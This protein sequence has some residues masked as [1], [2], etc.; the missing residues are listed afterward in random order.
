MFMSLAPGVEH[1]QSVEPPPWNVQRCYVHFEDNHDSGAQAGT[2]KSPV[3]TDQSKKRVGSSQANESIEGSTRKH[4]Q[5]IIDW[6]EEETAKEDASTYML[7][8]RQKRTKQTMQGDQPHQQRGRKKARRLQWGQHQ[9]RGH[10]KRKPGGHHKMEARAPPPNAQA[11]GNQGITPSPL[12]IRA[13]IYK[14][15]K[16]H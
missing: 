2:G 16:T 7:N 15:L 8:P 6:S 13:Q 12:Y 3:T 14:F 11:R 1:P 4:R 5:T 10:L 9:A